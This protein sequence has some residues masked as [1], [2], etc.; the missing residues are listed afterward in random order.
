MRFDI[1][2]LFPEIFAGVFDESIVKRAREANLVDIALHNIRD[3]TNDKHHV[4]DDT[5]Y[6]GGGGMVMKPEPIFAAVE[7]VL[8][9]ELGSLASGNVPDSSEP[10]VQHPTSNLQPPTSNLQSPVSNLETPIPIILLTPQ[11]RVF[12]QS[13]ARELAQKPRIA[14]I[15]G[16]YEGVDERVR[17]HLATD[18]ISIGDYVLTGGEIPAMV[19]VDAVTRLIPGVLGDPN[20]PM[21]DSH[22]AGLL[23]GPHYTR[24]ADFRGWTVPD[25]LLSGNHAEVDKWRRREALRW[26]FERRPDLLSRVELS[27]EER[28]FLRGLGWT[29][30]GK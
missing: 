19:I 22:A 7:V 6:A 28:E 8:G 30:S 1:F 21:K 5:P 12:D 14:L 16:H 4:T 15:C 9:I 29:P 23:E 10:N 11:G 26:T 25:I 13:I 20:A 24:P 2:T 27:E 3:Y 17:R 18:E